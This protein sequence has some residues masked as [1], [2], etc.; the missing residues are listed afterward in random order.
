MGETAGQP[1]DR[2]LEAAVIVS[3]RDLVPNKEAALVHV[4]Y[5]SDAR[6]NV[7]F[8]RVWS[9][10]VRGFWRLICTHSVSDSQNSRTRF[11]EGFASARLARIFEVAMQHQDVF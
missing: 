7:T 2:I 8:L 4:E 6:G 3:W 10:T 5:D 1:L 11:A 9:S